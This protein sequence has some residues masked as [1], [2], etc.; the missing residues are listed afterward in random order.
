MADR[1][2]IMIDGVLVQVGKP[3]ELYQ[4][5]ASENVASF[6]SLPNRFSRGSMEKW[7][8]GDLQTSSQRMREAGFPPM[9]SKLWIESMANKDKLRRTGFRYCYKSH[10]WK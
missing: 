6:L 5:P 4:K 1:I 7:F 3:S 9:S 8:Q 2:G 10:P